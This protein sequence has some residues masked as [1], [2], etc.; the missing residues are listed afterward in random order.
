LLLKTTKL[1]EVS[2]L[3]APKTCYAKIKPVG[4][5][6]EVLLGRDDGAIFVEGLLAR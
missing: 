1:V 5:F 4:L 3:S 6:T 2:Q